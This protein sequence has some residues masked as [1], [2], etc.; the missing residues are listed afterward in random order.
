MKVLVT[1]GSGF[2]G[3]AVCRLLAERGDEVVS[4]ARGEAP[5]LAALGVRH[6]CGD[7][8]ALE[9]V[10]N[11]SQGMDAVIHVAGKAGDWG[12]LEE[13]Y[14]ANVAGTDNVIAAC[15]MNAIP[16][17]VYTST[18]SVVHAGND[19]EGG[20]ESLPYARHFSSH[21]PR[22][23]ALAEQRVLKANGPDLATVAL[24]PHLIFG[25]GDRQ[26]FPRIVARRRAGRL[27]FIAPGGKRVDVTYIDN[28]AQAHL[29]ALDR[30]A[31]GAAAAGHAYFISQGQPVVLEQIVN[32]MLQIAGL[33]PEHRYLPQ[34]NAR[35]LAGV[36]EAVWRTLRLSSDPPL[37]RF[38]VEQLSTS[39]WFDITAA[40]RD[41]GYQPKATMGEGLARLSEW[42]IREGREQRSR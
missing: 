17:L 16:R 19:I 24:R 42:W 36:L 25:P 21:Y 39:H 34:R 37:T 1:G 30:L 33:P 35:L 6:L 15:F 10:L 13:Y 31:P 11:A 14:A 2:L 9:S 7:I 4:L 8:T 12:T 29:D 5:A 41:L 32:Q 20:N 38:L 3:G 40:R 26:L 23:K 27:R 18:P 28:A 22:T